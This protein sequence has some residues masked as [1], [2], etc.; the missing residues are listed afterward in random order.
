MTGRPFSGCH[1]EPNRLRHDNKNPGG[2][3][4][5]QNEQFA[6]HAEDHP[7]FVIVMEDPGFLVLQDALFM[8]LVAFFRSK[9][10]AGDPKLLSTF[11]P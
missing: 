8:K 2:L 10:D 9:L 11:H 1:T 3:Q 7:A 4:S 5:S 6:S